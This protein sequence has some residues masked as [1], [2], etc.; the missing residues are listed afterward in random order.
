MKE[1][2]I[3]IF[4]TTLRDGQ[5]CPWAGMTKEQNIEFAHKLASAMWENDIIEA[6]FPASSEYEFDIVSTISREIGSKEWS[7]KIAALCQLIEE[8]VVKTI[9][10]LDWCAKWKWR[11]HTY[12]PV[13]PVL[14]EA[15]I[16]VT[17]DNIAKKQEFVKNVEK[18]CKLASDAWLEVQFSPEWYSRFRN[19]QDRN[20]Q[21]EPWMD[22]FDF[23]TDLICAALRW[24]ASQINF[25][26]TIWWACKL[27]WDEYFINDINKHIAIVKERFPDKN[28][29][30][31]VHCHNDMWKA[32]E[33]SIN[34]LIDTDVTTV[35]CAVNGVWERAGN[36]DMQ[37]V[38]MTIYQFG[39][40]HGLKTD[41]DLSKLSELSDYIRDNMLPR[42][43]NY[44]ITWD[45]ASKHASGGHANAIIKNPLAYQPYDPVVVWKKIEIVWTPSSWSNQTVYLLNE[46][47][48]EV[49]EFEKD[50]FRDFIKEKYKER[51]KW[52]T[53]DEL[54]DAFMEFRNI[55]NIE[56][57]RYSRPNGSATIFIQWKV[58]GKEIDQKI[59]W[60]DTP[61]QV[62]KD[63]L[64]ILLPGYKIKKFNM[65]SKWWTVDADAESITILIDNQWNEFK[66]IW[67]DNDI[68]ISGL[69]SQ[70]NAFNKAYISK[71]YHN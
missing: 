50:I 15:S 33:N 5:Q 32:V 70:I 41:F 43:P 51:R 1:K 14:M 67:L 21:E 8:Q 10:A 46:L 57:I 40:K 25:P 61:M 4:D 34:A 65:W 22:N 19:K 55:T 26:D 64:D 37:Q 13:D 49:Y 63:R 3:R 30:F 62:L 17:H 12:V 59:E 16:N 9:Q 66:W 20:N 42:Q 28:V 56:K 7:A 31:S 45:N 53:N 23:V 36:T 60:E 11:L 6:G 38:L 35:E 24:W 18:Y 39:A 71:H 68:V 2:S 69:K 54:I 44:P 29:Q 47:W 58:L 48:Y 52:I 27:E